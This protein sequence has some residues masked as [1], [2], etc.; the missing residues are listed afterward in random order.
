MR[1]GCISCTLRPSTPHRPKRRRSCHHDTGCSAGDGD[2]RRQLPCVAVWRCQCLGAAKRLRV[3]GLAKAPRDTRH[4]LVLCS[5]MPV[6]GLSPM[7]KTLLQLSCRIG[8][9]TGAQRLQPSTDATSGECDRY[10]SNDQPPIGTDHAG[11]GLPHSLKTADGALVVPAQG[12]P[13]ILFLWAAE[14]LK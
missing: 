11:L 13:S 12:P 9:V 2:Q 1:T 6:S 8:K 7:N 10:P 4:G 5:K 14:S 3:V